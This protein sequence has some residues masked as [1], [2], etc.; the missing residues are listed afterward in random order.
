M[1]AWMDSAKRVI[2][3]AGSQCRA[4]KSAVVSALRQRHVGAAAGSTA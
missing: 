2:G 1:T 4:R 3:T